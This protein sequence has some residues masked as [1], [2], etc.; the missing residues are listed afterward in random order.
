MGLWGLQLLLTPQVQPVMQPIPVLESPRYYKTVQNKV[1]L[2]SR[3]RECSSRDLAPYLADGACYLPFSDIPGVHLHPVTR[4]WLWLAARACLIPAPAQ[5]CQLVLFKDLHCPLQDHFALVNLPVTASQ[6]GLSC[7]GD[8]V[9]CS[10]GWIHSFLSQK[11]VSL[12]NRYGLW[13]TLD[14]LSVGRARKLHITEME[15][16]RRHQHCG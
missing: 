9:S 13:V 5:H 16:T 3:Q 15:R 7:S 2:L 14:G 1:V 11:W 8:S 4:L 10:F 6:C 12:D